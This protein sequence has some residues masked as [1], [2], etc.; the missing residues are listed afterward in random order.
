[1]SKCYEIVFFTAS[2]SK[3]AKPLLEKIDK[4]SVA[5]AHLYRGSCLY[6][7]DQ[8]IKDLSFLGRD[9]S[10][11]IIVDNSPM[12]YCL[13]PE[14]AVPIKSWFDDPNDNELLDLIPILEALTKVK[15]VREVL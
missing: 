15:D 8:Y 6:Y 13:Q 12:A 11:T 5:A 1:M 4:N 7:K 14:N 2:L 9:L 10:K 3:Y